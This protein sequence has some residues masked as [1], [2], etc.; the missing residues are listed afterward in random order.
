MITMRDHLI[1]FQVGPQQTQQQQQQQTPEQ[2]K[3]PRS[4]LGEFIVDDFNLFVSPVRAVL[5]EFI[6]QIKRTG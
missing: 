1:G 5:N 6:R 4:P 3:P 2:E